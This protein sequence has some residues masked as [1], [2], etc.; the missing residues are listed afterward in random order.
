[1]SA[2]VKIYQWTDASPGTAVADITGGTTNFVTE[3]AYY[4]ASPNNI[5]PVPAVGTNYSYW[6]SM[7]LKTTVAP[8]TLINNLIF[9]MTAPWAGSG[10]VTFLAQTANAGADAGYRQATG[11]LGTTGT[12]LTLPNHSGLSAAPVDP[13]TFTSAAP[14]TLVGSTAGIGDFGDFMVVQAAIAAG[15]TGTLQSTSSFI[16]GWDET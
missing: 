6:L 2:T 14:K 13:F 10:F 8:V 9:Y 15:C 7:R 1:M 5:T 16:F 11:T 12:E 3:D 4:G